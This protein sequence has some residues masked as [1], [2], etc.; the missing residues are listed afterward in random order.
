MCSMLSAQVVSFIQI[1]IDISLNISYLNIITYFEIVT[2]RIY[3][4]TPRTE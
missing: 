4:I 1:K 3:Q 2:S